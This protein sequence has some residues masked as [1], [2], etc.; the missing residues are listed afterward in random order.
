MDENR[1][2]WLGKNYSLIMNI[3]ETWYV[4]SGYQK[5]WVKKKTLREAIDQ[6]MANEPKP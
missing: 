2:E 3:G 6:G 1:I 5:P 4:L